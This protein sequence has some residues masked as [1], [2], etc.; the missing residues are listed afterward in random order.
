MSFHGDS[1]ISDSRGRRAKLNSP[2]TTRA[3]QS[4]A[5]PKAL[6]TTVVDAQVRVTSQLLPQAWASA[7]LGAKSR[8]GEVWKSSHAT[9][10]PC[11]M[12]VRR[13]AP[14]SD[15]ESWFSC[16]IMCCRINLWGPAC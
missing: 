12:I 4:G 10:A 2:P 15:L 1:L 11:P 9:G 8:A 14:C 3:G 7:K 6:R 16:L 5:T 13:S